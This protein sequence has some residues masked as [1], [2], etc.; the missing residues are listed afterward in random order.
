VAVLLVLLVPAPEASALFGCCSP[1]S[2]PSCSAG[3]AGM[4]YQRFVAVNVLGGLLWGVGVPLAGCLLGR[5]I[6]SIDRDLLPLT[7][8]VVAVSFPASSVVQAARAR[9]RNNAARQKAGRS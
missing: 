5:T 8:V 1:A 7:A 6:P 3:A 4:P 2:S 9:Q